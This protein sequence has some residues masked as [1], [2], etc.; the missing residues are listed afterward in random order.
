ME[1][2]PPEVIAY[3]A[4]EL[5]EALLLALNVWHLPFQAFLLRDVLPLLLQRCPSRKCLRCRLL[6]PPAPHRC[7]CRRCC[8]DC[9]DVAEQL[10]T[11]V[12]RVFIFYTRR[13][14]PDLSLASD[15]QVTHFASQVVAEDTWRRGLVA[16]YPAA[17]GR[18]TDAMRQHATALQTQYAAGDATIDEEEI[19]SCRFLLRCVQTLSPDER[20]PEA[21]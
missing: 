15:A 14:A 11:E 9:G 6:P 21:V 8:V 17:A 13:A 5:H 19:D 3:F 1:Y 12:F 2:L 10:L 18:W 4:A 16:R 20:Q 7:R